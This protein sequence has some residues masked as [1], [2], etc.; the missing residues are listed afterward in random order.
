[1]KIQ[2]ISEL[3]KWIFNIILVQWK[4]KVLLYYNNENA[5]YYYIVTIKM[6]GTR[7]L[8]LCKCEQ[9]HHFQGGK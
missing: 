8:S 4:Y 9:V 6:Q 1:M 3:S 5:R 7:V 2:G